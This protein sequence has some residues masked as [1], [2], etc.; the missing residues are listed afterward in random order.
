MRPD[1]CDRL[2]QEHARRLEAGLLR[3]VR[4]ASDARPG[5]IV[6]D[7]RALID[8][9]SNDYLGLARHPRLIEGLVDAA[10]GGVGARAS[11]LLGGHQD[12]HEALQRALADWIG[13]PRALL[14]STGYMAATGALS[15][16]LGR[17]DL[18]VQDRLNHACLIDGARLAGADLRRYR[19]ADAA[20]AAR[21]LASAPDRHSLLA[22]DSVFSMDGDVA[23]LVELAALAR[24][25][26]A[27][28]M[29]DE[30]HGLGVL[31]PEGRGACAAAGL[32]SDAVQVWMG[33]LGKALGGFGAVI[34][35]SETLI[36]ALVNGARSYIYTTA[37]PPALARATVVA[38]ELARDADEQRRHLQKL[39]AHWRAG[40][41]DLGWELLPS[42]TP[43]QPLIVGDSD[44]AVA[45][46]RRLERAGCYCPAVR[47]PTV[48]KGS[49]R[50]RISFSAAH[51]IDDVEALL[52]ALGRRWQSSNS[53]RRERT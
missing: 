21:Q 26:R 29:V 52:H 38:V 18:C 37:L 39:I 44:T 11:H 42:A 36:D 19:H 13:F 41:N 51:T 40:A 25:E 33:T 8:F 32:G 24:R 50:L 35:G 47:P 12:A 31:G 34:A 20:D 1:F 6:L 28:L 46:S 43:I 48:P 9:G 22:T 15:A 5:R 16:L 10:K 4:T 3:R 2:T 53:S 30:A 17:H 7:G 23:P 45:L 49:A 27:W 14:F